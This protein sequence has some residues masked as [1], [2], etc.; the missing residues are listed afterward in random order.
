[1]TKM[2]QALS[3]SGTA[4]N[5]NTLHDI[6]KHVDNLLMSDVIPRLANGTQMHPIG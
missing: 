5:T 3:D 1:M 4:A 6:N 2:L